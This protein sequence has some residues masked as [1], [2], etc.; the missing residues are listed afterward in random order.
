MDMGGVDITDKKTAGYRLDCKSKNPFYLRIFFDAIDVALDIL[1][2]FKIVVVRALIGRY[3]KC[4]RLV[5]TT[6]PSK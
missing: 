2:D 6:R 4:N 3:S 5:P 1:V